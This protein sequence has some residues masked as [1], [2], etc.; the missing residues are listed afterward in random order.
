MQVRQLLDLIDVCF[1]LLEPESQKSIA[2]RSGLHVSTVRR[3]ARGEA[4]LLTRF[5][6]VQALAVAAG[7][8]VTVERRQFKLRIAR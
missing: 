7:L 3:L 4:T 8:H 6:T 5:G 1:G 2:R